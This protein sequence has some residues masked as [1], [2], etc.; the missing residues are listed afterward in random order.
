M[1][2]SLT[3]HLLT[4]NAAIIVTCMNHPFKIKICGV[5]SVADAK[6]VAESPADAIGLN[7]YPKSKRYVDLAAALK[8]V[9]AVRKSDST[10]TIAGVFVNAEQ[11]DILL[12]ASELTLDAIQL[13]GDEKPEFLKQLIIATEKRGLQFDFIRAIRTRPA[14]R[15]FDGQA[16]PTI[17][18][19]QTGMDLADLEAE[20]KRWTDAGAAAIL[21]DAAVA[22]DFGGTGKQVDWKGFSRLKSSVPKILA[23]GLTPENISDALNKAAPAT[24]DVASGV[25]STPGIKDEAKIRSLATQARDFFGQN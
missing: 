13:H 18:T 24:V 21:I 10:M 11:D 15:Q 20:I 25:E 9:A 19:D 6:M 12:L 1:F 23:G 5:T 8:I 14:D 7:F 3:G 17:Q 4:V 16:D 22:G 2:I